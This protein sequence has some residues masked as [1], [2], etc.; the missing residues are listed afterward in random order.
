MLCIKSVTD[1]QAETN[2][3]PQFLPNWGHKNPPFEAINFLGGGGGGNVYIGG[4]G[5][6]RFLFYVRPN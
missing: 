2:M 6:Q 1:E 5:K 4:S 3:L